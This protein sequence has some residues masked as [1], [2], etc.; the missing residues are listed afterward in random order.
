MFVTKEQ[1]KEKLL[2]KIDDN[3]DL[4]PD[5]LIHV[6]LR[7]IEYATFCKKQNDHS[8]R[9]CVGDALVLFGSERRQPKDV[10]AKM[11]TRIKRTIFP[12]GITS[13]HHEGERKFYEKYLAK[14]KEDVK[15]T[16]L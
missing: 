5:I 14:E 11:S 3:I 16:N 10:I 7:Q 4:L 12:N 9:E 6:A 8:L 15:Q 13:S 2:K 1:R